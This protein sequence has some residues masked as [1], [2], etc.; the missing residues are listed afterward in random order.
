MTFI[1]PNYLKMATL[2]YLRN[3]HLSNICLLFL[4]VG[5]QSVDTKHFPSMKLATDLIYLTDPV[6]ITVKGFSRKWKYTRISWY[7][8]QMCST[9]FITARK[10]SLRRLCFYTCLS[11]CPQGESD[12]RGCLI[13]GGLVWGGCLLPGVWSG[14]GVPAPGGSGPGSAWSQGKGGAWSRGVWRPPSWDG[15]CCGRYASSWNAF[16]L[17]KYIRW[18]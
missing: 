12:S 15:Y 3:F 18:R 16:L 5:K 6:N 7:K 10:R 13:P 1:K 9:W 17:V 8:K 11:F 2:L 4:V 14:G